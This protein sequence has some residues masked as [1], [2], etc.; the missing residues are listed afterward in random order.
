[1]KEGGKFM[2]NLIDGMRV[3]VVEISNVLAYIFEFNSIMLT[4]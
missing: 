1:M 2:A 3:P 4:L